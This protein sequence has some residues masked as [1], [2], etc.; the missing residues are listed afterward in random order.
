MKI[1][2]ENRNYYRDTFDEVHASEALLRKVEAMKQETI[3]KKQHTYPHRGYAAAAIAAVLIFS[4]VITYAA[5]GNLWILSITMPDGKTIEKVVEAPPG[6]TAQDLDTETPTAISTKSAEN[7]VSAPL[8]DQAAESIPATLEIT[9]EKTYLVIDHT[10]RIDITED[11]QDG[12]CKGSYEVDEN[13]YYCYEVTG[14]L[15]DYQIQVD[16]ISVTTN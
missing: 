9:Q 11:F 12:N 5:S 4:N 2:Q 6:E 15:K 1:E 14:T 10:H 8:A 16:I 7:E 3:T 13:T